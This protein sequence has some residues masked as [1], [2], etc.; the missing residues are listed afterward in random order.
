MITAE[1]QK[2]PVA[3]PHA[4]WKLLRKFSFARTLYEERR[5]L[6]MASKPVNLGGDPFSLNVVRALKAIMML[7]T[8]LRGIRFQFVDGGGTELDLCFHKQVA[9]VQIHA[10]WLSFEKVHESGLC[11]VLR[12]TDARRAGGEAFFCDH[13]VEDL[14]ET[15]L[16]TGSL[17]CRISLSEFRHL[18]RR[19]RELLRLMPRL[20]QVARTESIGELEVHWI[21]NEGGLISTFCN[22]NIQYL[23]TL[24]RISSC[25]RRWNDVLYVH[26]TGAYLSSLFSFYLA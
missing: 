10:K 9:L 23:V 11:E 12:L 16:S 13:V 17:N 8:N 15:L 21:G 3:V 2:T 20:V 14:L 1:F 7:H 4:L 18:R 6:F 24:H 25:Q 26:G 19:M 5:R 22:S